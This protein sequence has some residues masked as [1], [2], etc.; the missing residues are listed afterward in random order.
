MS[1]LE[2]W[3]LSRI[4]IKNTQGLTTVRYLGD[5]LRFIANQVFTVLWTKEP[6]RSN[7]QAL[8]GNVGGYW[9][10][11]SPY[12]V[13]SAPHHLPETFWQGH[14]ARFP[15]MDPPRLVLNPLI[16]GQK[17]KKD[18]NK[19]HGQPPFIDGRYVFW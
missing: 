10:V 5:L 7:C 9:S 19:G 16:R 11:F 8:R 14:I 17:S 4:M 18:T 15:S 2:S 12:S 6:W 1:S 13:S 3:T